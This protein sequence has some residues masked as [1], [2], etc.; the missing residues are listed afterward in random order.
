ME[1]IQSQL[2]HMHLGFGVCTFPLPSVHPNEQA[3]D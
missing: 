1:S 2:E 3:K